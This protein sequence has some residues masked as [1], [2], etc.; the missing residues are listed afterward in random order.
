MKKILITGG[1]GNLGSWLSE[2]FY[3]QGYQVSILS[4]NSRKLEID[5]KYE[6]ISC[7]ISDL[8]DCLDKLGNSS[9]D[10]VIHAASVNDGFVAD[11]P[12]LALEVNTWGTR[13]L[14]EVFKD[15]G[16]KNFIYLS[17]FQVYGKYAGA[18]DENTPL[19]PRN[20]YGTSHLFAEYYVKQFHYNFKMPFTII[21]LTN[22]F[23]CPKDY[24]SS[25]W[26]LVL[27]DLARTAFEK[28]EIVLKSN[29]KAPR[30]F[31]W[32]GDVCTALERLVEKEASNEIFNISGEQTLR[33]KDVADFVQQA[34]QEFAG[35]TLEVKV[36]NEDKS[37]FPDG[38]SVSAQKLRNFIGPFTSGPKFKEEAKN[39]F[40]F[41]SKQT[42]Q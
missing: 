36:N 37:E 30:D 1:L 27:N 24:N 33:M 4:K 42:V 6:Y 15:K 29:G 10:Y 38:L 18:I 41:L 13:N 12:R 20:D 8:K 21:R 26:Y 40:A 31:I 35:T 7:D 19:T 32:M 28:K 16:L 25:K 3:R 34:Y 22:S 2:H 39:I 14:L 17:T 11:Y 5:L 23:G 9:F